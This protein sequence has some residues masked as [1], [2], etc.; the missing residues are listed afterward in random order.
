MDNLEITVPTPK[1]W[2]DYKL[3]RI[4]TLIESP[5]AFGQTLT[6]LLYVADEEWKNRLS[7]IDETDYW[8]FF[9]RVDGEVVGMLI[10]RT[11]EDDPTIAKIYSVFVVE[12]FRRQGVARKLMET[13]LDRFIKA[14]KFKKVQL[15]VVTSQLPAINFY[16]QFGFSEKEKVIKD[17]GDG[18]KQER[19]IMEKPLV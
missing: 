9:A 7:V 19:W 16:N 3:I 8:I 5:N 13:L 10:G 6:D 18:R 4:Q 17:L 1:D 15:E 14:K 12:K 11:G 2:Q